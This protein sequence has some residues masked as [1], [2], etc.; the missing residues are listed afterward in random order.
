MNI[1]E[2]I[3]AAKPVLIGGVIGAVAALTVAYSANLVVS[4]STMNERVTE[5]QVQA[6]GELCEQN[7]RAH[8]LSE[9]NEL[10]ALDGWRNEAR[11]AL[12]Q[13]FAEGMTEDASLND[14]IA[15]RCDNLLQPA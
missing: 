11:T 6:Y 13:Q 3:T 14:G 8:W 10:A 4:T 1:S 5:A 15:D 7:A 9:G 2:K 12:A